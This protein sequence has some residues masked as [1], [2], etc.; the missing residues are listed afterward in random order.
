MLPDAPKQHLLTVGLE[1]YFQV[2]AFRPLIEHKQW[3]RFETR[4]EQNTRK[5]LDLLDRF[6]IQA[7][8]FVNG[9]VGDRFPELVRLVADR[10]HEIAD[11][12]Y[13]HRTIRQMTPSEFREDLAK[14]REALERA[15]GQKVVGY[16]VSH[17]WFTP[18][19]LW[20]LDVLADEGYAYDAS[21]A[22]AWRRFAGEPWR[23]FQHEHT[24]RKQG[25]E[26][27][28]SEI[29]TPFSDG[30]RSIWEFPRSSYRLLGLDIPIAGGNY[31]R[32]FPQWLVKRAVAA[33]HRRVEAPF[34]MY[35]HVWELDPEQPKINAVSFLQRIRHYRNLDKMERVL[36][37]YF[38]AYSFTG[39]ADYLGL[40]TQRSAAES[41]RLAPRVGELSRSDSTTPVE[42]N[43]CGPHGCG[44][45]ADPA[46]T[47]RTPISK[48][49]AC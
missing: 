33:W 26:L 48:V 23:R 38:G 22:P 32:Q 45:V 6:D 13:Y 30:D 18:T 43:G 44:P 5:A 11:K 49:V 28:H 24:V 35:F 37:D 34:V 12:G 9:W 3:Y 14:S 20:A 46:T 1:D 16:R 19:D 7:T 39:I 2:A 41:S 25:L 10:G 27:S 21:L 40:D 42:R 17:G 47:A 8:F 15:C 29:P 31:F 4:L 36:E